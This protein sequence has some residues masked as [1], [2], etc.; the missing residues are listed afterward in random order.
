MHPPRRAARVTRLPGVGRDAGGLR[1]RAAARCRVA[2]AAAATRWE[3]VCTIFGENY[4]G[5]H[6][7]L[8]HGVRKVIINTS[9]LAGSKC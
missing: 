5:I 6:N 3:R 9:R 1:L 8:S 7:Y 4:L 2:A